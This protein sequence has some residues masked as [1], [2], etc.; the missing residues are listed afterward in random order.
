MD[1][2]NP[3]HLCQLQD[4]DHVE[5]HHQQR[6]SDEDAERSTG[7]LARRT[8]VSKLDPGRGQCLQ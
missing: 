1:I 6:H 7:G 2:P 8:Q 5:L 4:V 3:T